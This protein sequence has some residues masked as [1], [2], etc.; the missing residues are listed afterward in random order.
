MLNISSITRTRGYLIKTH[1]RDNERGRETPP[2]CGFIVSKSQL[3]FA[4]LLL[5]KYCIKSHT[6]ILKG[7]VQL[8]TFFNL[9]I[10]CTFVRERETNY[11]CICDKQKVQVL[12]QS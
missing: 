4:V 8:N 1:T 2:V 7:K 6:L 12:R 5:I 9:H 11:V 10:T 3:S